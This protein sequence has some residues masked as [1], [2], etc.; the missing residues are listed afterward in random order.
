MF[1]SSVRFH[2]VMLGINRTIR[3]ACWHAHHRTDD[4]SHILKMCSEE[5]VKIDCRLLAFLIQIDKMWQKT[6]C[7]HCARAGPAAQRG[8]P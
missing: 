3:Q 8:L 7:G 5:K 1:F 2:E 6:W 4:H